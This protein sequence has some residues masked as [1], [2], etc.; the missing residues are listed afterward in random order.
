MLLR[1]FFKAKI[2][3][4]VIFL[5]VILIGAIWMMGL[6]TDKSKLLGFKSGSNDTQVVTAMTKQKQVA[7]LGL[8]VTDI[9]DK[10]QATTF[11]GM[12]VPFSEKTAYLKGTFDAKLGFDGKQVKIS[13]SKTE[14]K[15]YNIV[16]PKFIVIGIN[17]PKF[18]IIDNKG[19]ILSFVTE[20]IDTHA[21]ANQAMS[22]KTLN[23]YIKMNKE[24][25][26]EQSKNYYENILKSIDKELKIKIKF[27]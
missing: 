12:D 15:M 16:I 27:E 17:N 5:C 20:E 13:K 19:E 18:E 3:V 1:N 7:V 25:L 21:L 6:S 14:N 2:H 22:E 9:Y 11:L 26:Q 10:S 23:K 24:W 8:S 4:W